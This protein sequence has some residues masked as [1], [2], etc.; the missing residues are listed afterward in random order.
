MTK[1]FDFVLATLSRSTQTFALDSLSTTTNIKAEA[2]DVKDIIDSNSQVKAHNKEED[3]S[4]IL[5]VV[6][7]PKEI[8]FTEV[9]INYVVDFIHIVVMIA[10]TIKSRGMVRK[11]G[12]CIHF[13]SKTDHTIH[14]KAMGT[15]SGYCIHFMSS[16]VH[17]VHFKAM[18]THPEYYNHFLSMTDRA[19]HSKNLANHAMEYIYFIV[20]TL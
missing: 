19:I 12:D 16:T 4:N 10:H 17:V 7:L 3:L 20:V 5:N 15:H 11:V 8:N 14:S 9:T 1:V 6:F 2:L 13:V 18:A